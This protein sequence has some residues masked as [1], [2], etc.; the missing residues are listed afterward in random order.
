MSNDTNPNTVAAVRRVIEE[1]QYLVD[2]PRIQQ[3][4]WVASGKNWLSIL[5]IALGELDSKQ[6]LLSA[7][8]SEEPHAYT[9]VGINVSSGQ[10]YANIRVDTVQ[11]IEVY[12]GGEVGH[13]LVRGGTAVSHSRMELNI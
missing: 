4:R 1:M 13:R 9:I 10:R 8:E 2:H 12:R 6:T 7:F 11:Y 5:Q 3:R